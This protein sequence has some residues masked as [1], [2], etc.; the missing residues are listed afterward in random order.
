MSYSKFF[1]RAAWIGL[2]AMAAAAD[3]SLIEEIVAKVNGDIVTRGELEK[4]RAAIAAERKQ[5]GAAMTPEVESV[6]KE[7]E[8]NILRDRIDQLLLIQKGKELGINV[9]G[10][11]SKQMAELQSNSNIADPEKFQ[12]FVKEQ[13]GMPYEDYRAEM[14]NQFLTQRVVRQE[15]GRLINIPRVDLLKYYEEHKTEFVRKDQVFLSEIFLSTAGKTP[16]EQEAISKK[17]VDLVARSRKGERFG[18]LAKANS[19]STT[20]ENYGQLG[21]FLKDDLKADLI[22][23]V[24]EQERGF[25]TDP[26]RQA[27]PAGYLILRVDERHR[28]GQASFEEV[29]Q[30]VTERLYMPIFQPKIREYLTALRQD[31]FLEI[32]AGYTDSS[33]APGKSTGWSDPAALRPE[34]VTKEE[35]ALMPR[36]RRLL[37]MVPVPGTAKTVKGESSS[38]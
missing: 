34:T 33:A 4:S 21:G 10:D 32:K 7:R 6:L 5:R 1:L 17:A 31:A 13:T 9:D 19:D 37:W 24:W 25:V 38:Q 23:L 35:V 11:V 18:E 20:R 3:V 28:P 16:A 8:S 15:V 12:Q 14:A 36:R 29:E 30:V 27:E 2:A 26:I 22:N